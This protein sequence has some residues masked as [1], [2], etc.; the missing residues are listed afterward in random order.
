MS[1]V[2]KHAVAEECRRKGRQE[3]LRLVLRRRGRK[4]R[5]GRLRDR[6]DYRVHRAEF[7]DVVERCRSKTSAARVERREVDGGWDRIWRVRIDHGVVQAKLRG[8]PEEL[9]SDVRRSSK[10]RSERRDEPILSAAVWHGNQRSR[11]EGLLGEVMEAIV[12][13]NA[14]F[15]ARGS[16][17]KPANGPENRDVKVIARQRA[18]LRD[19]ER[20]RCVCPRLRDSTVR[21]RV[22]RRRVDKVHERNLA[23]VVESARGQFDSGPHAARKLCC[24]WRGN[25]HGYIH[26][27]ID[28][29]R[30]ISNHHE[31]ENGS[32][33]ARGRGRVFLDFCLKPLGAGSERG[34]YGTSTMVAWFPFGKITMPV[35]L[36]VGYSIGSSGASRIETVIENSTTRSSPWRRSAGS[37]TH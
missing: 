28:R 17:A 26:G 35:G 5:N 20:R 6:I 3:D 36:G 30:T 27:S 12:D 33:R 2:Q 8:M 9:R 37:R 21:R 31:R 18:R 13:R 24:V 23:V 16:D 25:G 4:R 34:H 14:V 22:G 11:A 10:E 19:N 32:A 29:V 1:G 7:V 15:V